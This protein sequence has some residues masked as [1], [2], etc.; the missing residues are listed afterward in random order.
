MLDIVRPVES[1]QPVSLTD[2]PLKDLKVHFGR[3]PLKWTVRLNRMDL[4]CQFLDKKPKI[5]LRFAQI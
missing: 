4:Q 1:R 2:G 3:A 5:F